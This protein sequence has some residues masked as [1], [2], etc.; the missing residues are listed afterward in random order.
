[1]SNYSTKAECRHYEGENTKFCDNSK[2]GSTSSCSK[3]GLSG[4]LLFELD[5]EK[6]VSLKWWQWEKSSPGKRS[7]I[8]RNKEP[9]KHQVLGGSC[10]DS[11]LAGAY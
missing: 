5:L 11:R 2:G 9:R 6:W 1:M 4:R 7:R 10:Q 3:E 8:N